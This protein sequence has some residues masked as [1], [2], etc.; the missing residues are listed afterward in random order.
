MT[1]P[2]PVLGPALP[3][4]GPGSNLGLRTIRSMERRAVADSRARDLMVRV[5]FDQA[6]KRAARMVAWLMMEAGVGRE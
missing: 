5:Q 4:S 2:I 3:K 1:K 6:P